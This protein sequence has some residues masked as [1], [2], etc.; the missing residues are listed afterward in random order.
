MKD[1]I[2]LIGF[3]L[4]FMFYR[5]GDSPL[6]ERDEPKYAQP[7]WE[8][9]ATW[10]WI[11]PRFNGTTRF[12]K[13]PL[14]YWLEGIS[15][16]VFGKTEWAA[17][18]PSALA[19]IGI[20]CLTFCI[21]NI[22]GGIRCAL[23]SALILSSSLHFLL[24]CKLAVVD[25]TLTFFLT[26]SLF[27][28]IKLGQAV[29]KQQSESQLDGT[30]SEHRTGKL[31]PKK[32]NIIYLYILF[33]SM[34]L[35][36]LTKGP[37]GVLFPLGTAV[38][39]KIF[40]PINYKLSKKHII[41]SILLFFIIVIPWYSA[42][43]ITHGKTY[44]DTFF[45][46]HN[47]KRFLAPVDSHK[48]PVWFYLPIFFAGLFPWSFF[49][50]QS[51]KASIKLIEKTP[52]ITVLLLW[53]GVIFI[54]F[55][56]AKT[57]LGSYIFPIY[58]AI[59]VII[60]LF[61]SFIIENKAVLKIKETIFLSMPF[62]ISLSI[63]IGVLL[64]LPFFNA[65]ITKYG[66]EKFPME[67]IKNFVWIAI[68]GFTIAFLLSFPKRLTK[69]AFFSAFITMLILFWQGTTLILPIAAK[70]NPA[71]LL[72]SRL[73]EEK[74][75][76]SHRIILFDTINNGLVFYT[77]HTVEFAS[78][79]KR[80][81]L[82]LISQDLQTFIIFPIDKKSIIKPLLAASKWQLRGEIN[83]LLLYKNF[84]AKNIDAKNY[85]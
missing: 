78:T 49:L 8:M 42:I 17:R 1:W 23:L 31:I 55:S 75:S 85:N 30:I 20:L 41:G 84:G 2:I 7:A 11:T 33:I 25:A 14:F 62:F 56:I 24:Q 35:A 50:F 76:P 40:S 60:G 69:Y 10:N 52:Q 19:G 48:G 57:K 61:W 58:P 74:V 5:L 64:Y 9:V 18:F 16:M 59:A 82:E 65:E 28:I 80:S 26:L 6:W 38:L 71:K 12:D 22:A 66:Q 36:T 13:P 73:I 43:S 34:A 79:N 32:N 77:N 29:S 54:F 70:E 3:G 53:G 67:H 39:W 47:I 44:F 51:L 72:A 4:F 15:F 27:S 68:I 81:D 37:I 83:G 46:F 21:G 45:L 63:W